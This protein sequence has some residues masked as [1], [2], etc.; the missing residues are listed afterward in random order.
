VTT[1]PPLSELLSWPAGQ[2]PW[3]K[4]EEV[5]QRSANARVWALFMMQRTGKTPVILGTCA[6]QYG[7][8][9]NAGGVGP[10]GKPFDVTSMLPRRFVEARPGAKP[11]T[12]IE[13]RL[14]DLPKAPAHDFIYRPKSWAERGLDALV[15]VAM[16]SGVPAGWAEEIALRLPKSMNAKALVWDSSRAETVSFAREFRDLVSHTGFACLLLNGE[17]IPTELAKKAV[18]TFLRARRA[19]VVGDETSLICSQPG[20]VRSHVMEAIRKLPGAICRR[21]LDGT[22]GDEAPTD[23]FSQVRFLDPSILGESWTAFK[24]FYAVWETKGVWIKNPKTGKPE[25]RAIRAQAV[26]EAT[27]KKVYANLDVMAKKLAPISSRVQRSECFDVP[28]KLYTPYRFALSAAQRRVYDPLREEFEA[29]LRDGTIVTAAHALARMTRLDQVRGDWWPPVA[30]PMI[31]VACGGDGC[32]ACADVGAIMAKTAKKIIDPDRNPLI[33]AFV[34]VLS[35][36]KEPGIAWAT[37]D[38]TIDAMMEAAERAGRTAV[39]YDGKVSD[40]A[41]LANKLAFQ[42][43]CADLMIAKEASAGRGLNL[44]AAKWLCYVENGYS[45]R[46]RSQSEDRAEVAGREHGTGIIDLIAYDT[47]DEKKLLAHMNKGETSE[48]F[49]DFMRKAA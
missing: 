45:K 21:I 2:A 23:L 26:D 37:F 28:A 32:E 6:H 39:R 15:V 43:G 47:Y 7:R 46:K 29:E 4:Q 13:P 44:S 10:N 17:A 48:L 49:W 33:E 18:G 1:I 8:F 24:S 25:E 27:G 41:K 9:I 5:H 12:K 42:E 3:A 11:G 16:P 19:I 30:L 40:A 31:C 20:N 35:V 14:E 22:P 36:N 38:E 34:D